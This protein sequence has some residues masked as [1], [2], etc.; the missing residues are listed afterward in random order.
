MI[1]YKP[2]RYLKTAIAVAAV[3]LLLACAQTPP[4]QFVSH[5]HAEGMAQSTDNAALDNRNSASSR[6]DKDRSEGA[7]RTLQGT[8]KVFQAPA[9]QVAITGS[10]VKLNFEDAPIAQVV[11]TVLGDILK[12][13]YV[14]LPPIAGSVTMTTQK[15]IPPDQVLSLLET[16]LQ[17]SGLAMV[18]DTRGTYHIGTVDALRSV[19][20]SVRVA[21]V[22]APM[23]PG[24][25]VV[26]LPLQFIGAS[27]MA[28]ILRPMAGESAILR[29]DAVRNMLVMSGTRVQAEGWLEMVRTFD[30]DLLEGMSVGV[31]PLKYISIE[32]VTDALQA[33]QGGSGRSNASAGAARAPG[34]AAAGAQAQRP[35]ANAEAGS[36]GF[37]STGF[38]S[39]ALHVMPIERLN[40]I[41]V[42]T[43]RPAYLDQVKRWITKFD[44]AGAIGGQ[45]QLHIYH[46][47][48]G[49]AKHLSNVLSGIFGGTASNNGTRADSGVAP[50]LNTTVSGSAMG[51]SGNIGLRLG[52]GAGA[53]NTG[54]GGI[55]TLGR[56]SGNVAAANTGVSSVTTL[57]NIRVMADELNNSVLIWGTPAEYERIETA[58]RKLDVPPTQVLIE[59]SIIE[60]TLNDSLRYGLEWSFNNRDGGYSGAG[61]LLSGSSKSVGEAL[62]SGFTYTISN[63]AGRIRA[64]LNALSNKTNLKVV[65]SP[66]L[67]VLDNHTASISVGTQQPFQSG[68]TISGSDSNVITTNIQYK[69]TGVGLSVTPSVNAGNM[70]TMNVDQT[71]TDVGAPDDVTKQRSFL[72][73]QISS[74]VAVRSGESI[75]MGGLIQESSSSGRSGVPLLHDLPLVGHLFGSTSKEGA[76]TELIVVITP[77]VVRTDVDIR[78]VTES[79]REQMGGLREVL[80]QAPAP[81]EQSPLLQ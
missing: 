58:L 36:S 77:R 72:Q 7:E 74:R 37:A 24:F 35:A 1:N 51:S 48:N 25:G 10:P 4:N 78:G 75:V 31:F 26:I 30:I 47:Q 27:E 2:Q 73:R 55:N 62:A 46:V 32:E 80:Y 60:V 21:E 50:G 64:A 28:S 33:L 18:R 23:A 49:N 11:Q 59:A 67:M 17:A 66:T 71:V 54:A 44:Q 20:A 79:L 45:A 34:A 53:S 43:S 15:P 57:G 29:V 16:A 3:Q 38:L 40:S 70:V 81:A 39:G 41:L 19:G 56:S 13:D 6:E 22:G 68:S 12:A 5:F 9:Q 76:R 14:L 63:S 61:S 8:G 52:A 42:I 65:A 69:D